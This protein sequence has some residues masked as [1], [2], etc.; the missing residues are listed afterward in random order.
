MFT[1]TC[2]K[3]GGDNT[4]VVEEALE[5]AYVTRAMNNG[6]LSRCSFFSVDVLYSK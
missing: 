1:D 5:M 4:M 2:T 6:I 3:P